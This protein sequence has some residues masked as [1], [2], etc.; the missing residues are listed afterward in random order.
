MGLGGY[1]AAKSE[2]DHYMREMKREEEEIINVPDTEAA[3][4]AEILAEYG[5]EPHEYGP[6]VEAL[7]KRPQAWLEFMMRFELGLEKPEPRR[8][9]ESAATIAIAYVLGGFV[10]LSPYFFIPV[11]SNAVVVSVAVT[12]VALLFFGYVKGRL[13]GNRPFLSALQTTLIG[14]IASAAAFGLA[15]AV[16]SL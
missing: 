16:K 13:T 14:A 8:A 11:A 7:R 12:L 15:K 1:L 10:P 9:L 3:E 5:L 4:V 2:A 6:V